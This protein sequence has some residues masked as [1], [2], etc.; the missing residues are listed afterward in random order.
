[1]ALSKKSL[2][3]FII[4]GAIILVIAIKIFTT[5]SSKIDPV[6]ARTLGPANAKV[7]I[8]EFIDFECP[9]CAYGAKVLKEYA[10]L[11]PDQIRLQVKYFPLMNIHRHALQVA[12]YAECTARQGKFWPFFEPLSAQQAQW[13]KL[14]AAG[15]IFDQLAKAAGADMGQ[16]KSCLVSED[17]STTIMAEKTLGRSLGVQS[18]P[19][20]FIND[21]MVVGTKSLMDELNSYFPK[22]PNNQPK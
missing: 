10:V 1:M 7:N 12:S 14:I 9:A 15:D 13:T 8:V 22:T 16:L 3:G 2:T 20:Y 11:Y 5:N 18:T 19:T 17:V 4:V 21:K 6:A